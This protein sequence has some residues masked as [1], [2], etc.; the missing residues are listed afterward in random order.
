[1]STRNR[2]VCPA[3]A[4]VL[5][6]PAVILA[7]VLTIDWY[8]IDGGGGYCAGG[9]YE[10]ESTIGQPDA[11]VLTGGAFELHGGFWPP[12]GAPPVA[13]GCGDLDDSGV[14][15][16]GDFALFAGCFGLAVPSDDC[17]AD[18]YFCADLDGSGAIDLVD[19]SLF[20]GAFGLSAEGNPPDCE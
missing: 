13:C 4:A 17:P 18:V 3:A 15:N 19:F 5:M 16:L 9:T 6:F 2:I 14:V 1:M 8:T 12:A 11:G 7:Q 10:L 20:S